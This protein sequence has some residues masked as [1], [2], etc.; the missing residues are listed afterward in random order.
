MYWFIILIYCEWKG[1][2][3]DICGVSGQLKSIDIQPQN[4]GRW[5][6]RGGEGKQ[7]ILLYNML[8]HRSQF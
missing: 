6:R 8:I 3:S 5:L 7:T 1:R 4:Y 2:V